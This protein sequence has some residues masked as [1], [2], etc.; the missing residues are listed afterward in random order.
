ML[1]RRPGV[2]AGLRHEGRIKRI[3]ARLAAHALPCAT[4]VDSHTFFV[5]L[6][7]FPLDIRPRL[8]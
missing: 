3:A 2:T 8:P 7:D 6:A 1:A 4:F 5:T